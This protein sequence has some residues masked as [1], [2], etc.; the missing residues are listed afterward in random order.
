MKNSEKGRRIHALAEEARER[1]DFQK[2][3]EYTDQ[4]TLVYQRDGDYVGLSEVQSSRQSTFKHLYRQTGDPSFLV[5]EEHAARAA[6]AIAEKSGIPEALGIPYHNLGK[7]YLEA[8]RFGEATKAFRSAVD[9]LIE[10]PSNSHS[11]PSVIADIK[12]HM[13]TALFFTGNKS[14]LEK[15]IAELETLKKA[16]EPSTYSKNAWIS[17]AHL[18]IAV[19]AAQDNPTLAKE[20]IQQAKSIINSDERQILRKQQLKRV[21][22]LIDSSMNRLH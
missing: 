22:A 13:Y 9:S 10:Y 3:L 6:V 17:G 20:H 2:A 4:A 18:R 12:G 15:A 11:R 14:A 21:E 19:M 5:L 16:D 7:Y 8:K 1:G